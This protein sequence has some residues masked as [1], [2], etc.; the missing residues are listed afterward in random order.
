MSQLSR[1]GSL[2]VCLSSVAVSALTLV[3]KDTI[4]LNINSEC[5]VI[6]PDQRD[7]LR[8]QRGIFSDSAFR[9]NGDILHDL[10]SASLGKLCCSRV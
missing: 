6:T 10:I 3:Q 5:L 9:V 4:G 2:R 7:A 1:Q 8:D